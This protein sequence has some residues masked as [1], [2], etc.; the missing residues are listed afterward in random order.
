MKQESDVGRSTR[1][2][3]V[4]FVPAVSCGTK[5]QKRQPIIFE[6]GVLPLC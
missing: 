6:T 1:E 3:P 5:L 2:F 4:S